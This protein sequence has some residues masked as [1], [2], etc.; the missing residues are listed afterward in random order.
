MRRGFTLMEI[1]MGMALLALILVVALCVLQ[2]ALL[3]SNRQQA[4]TR[5]AFLAQEQMEVL[6]ATDE[7]QSGQGTLGNGFAWKAE[8]TP[9]EDFLQLVVRVKGP[10]GAVYTLATDRR[11]NIQSLVFR[12]QE[13]VFQTAEDIPEPVALGEGVGSD[14]CISPDGQQLAYVATYE[15]RPQIF[16]RRLHSSDAPQLFV[17]HPEGAEEPRF[18]PDGAQLAFTSQVNGVSQVFVYTIARRSFRNVSNNSHQEN[19]PGWFPDAKTLL[20][21]RDGSSIV[22]LLADGGEQ[23]LVAESGGWN[24]APST[25]GKS[26]V[27]MSSRDGNPEIYSLNLAS[28]KLSRLTDNP[29]YDTAP[30]L[31]GQRILFQSNRDGVQRLYSMNLDGSELTAVTP[32]Q[33]A[34]AP[35]WT[36]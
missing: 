34:E 3:G 4:Q 22:K 12:S 11:K 28:Q 2:W 21:C 1:L 26:L 15:G 25:D 35:Q 10:A 23:V 32:D 13:K 29:A 33:V 9:A 31:K 24:A 20:V 36:R 27:F 5:A 19:S 16:L 14:F 17:H 7:P 18:S 6:C 8:V 30:Q